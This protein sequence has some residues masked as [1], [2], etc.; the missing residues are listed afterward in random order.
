MSEREKKYR[1]TQ[2][3]EAAQ[4]GIKTV[5]IEPFLGMMGLQVESVRAS[6]LPVPVDPNAAPARTENVAF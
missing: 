5:G 2:K 3:K 6:R 4:L 1:E